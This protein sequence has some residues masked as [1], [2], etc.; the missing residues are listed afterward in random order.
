[1]P[2]PPPYYGFS[3]Y[4]P[5][6]DS[7]E[8]G[9][10]IPLIKLKDGTRD[11]YQL[12]QCEVVDLSDELKRSEDLFKAFWGTF[13]DTATVIV[14]AYR[15][16]DPSNPTPQEEVH[17]LS[18]ATAFLDHWPDTKAMSLK[19]LLDQIGSKTRVDGSYAA[20]EE[21]LKL[22]DV[23]VVPWLEKDFFDALA[24]YYIAMAGRYIA[25]ALK[26]YTVTG[27]VL[28]SASRE[29]KAGVR[30]DRKSVV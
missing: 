7:T 24:R 29:P 22:S 6:I 20:L 12:S 1:M 26:Q 30:V 5:T 15:P 25:Q 23:E 9:V 28:D 4:F 11:I 27:I 19:W 10:L 17:L 14:D 16:L 8:V 18:A 3:A 2:A 21:A 13:K